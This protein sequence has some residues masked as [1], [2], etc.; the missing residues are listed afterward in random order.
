MT[1]ARTLYSLELDISCEYP[2][3]ELAQDMSNYGLV[4]EL[5]DANGPGGGNPVYRFSS[6]NKDDLLAFA[7]VCGYEDAEE[8]LE[9]TN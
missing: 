9:E 4:A 1:K 6:F 7:E 8:F 2:T 3:S 5:I